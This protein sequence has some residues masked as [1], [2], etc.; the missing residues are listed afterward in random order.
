MKTF[1]VSYKYRGYTWVADVRAENFEDARARL[2]AIAGGDVD[3]ELVATIPA[4]CGGWLVR[5]LV[6]FRNWLLGY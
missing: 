2:D 6:S 3:G 5:P 1:L 4:W